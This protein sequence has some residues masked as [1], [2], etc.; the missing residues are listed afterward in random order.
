V[1]KVAETDAVTSREVEWRKR[2]RIVIVAP[3]EFEHAKQAPDLAEI[4][5][6]RRARFQFCWRNASAHFEAAARR[7]FRILRAAVGKISSAQQAK[8]PAPD[9]KRRCKPLKS[10]R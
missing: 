10:L 5:A 3:N 6:R 1:P 4:G 7:M 2:W 8:A 9:T